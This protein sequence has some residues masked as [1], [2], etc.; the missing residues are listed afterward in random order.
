MDT[1]KCIRSMLRNTCRSVEKVPFDAHDYQSV[2]KLWV[3][4]KKGLASI[5]Q[6]T[7]HDFFSF[8]LS[9]DPHVLVYSSRVLDD[10][11]IMGKVNGKYVNMKAPRGD[12]LNDHLS[13]VAVYGPEI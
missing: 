5:Q 12:I 2:V 4:Y 10:V 13:F 1:V 9:H 3:R 11:L 6:S 7:I 8:H